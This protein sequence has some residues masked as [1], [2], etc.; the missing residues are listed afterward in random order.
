MK[1]CRL[2]TGQEVGTTE[3]RVAKHKRGQNERRTASEA[4]DV[5]RQMAAQYSDAEIAL[6]LNRLRLKTGTGNTWNEVRVRSLRSHWK[7]GRE[8]N[9]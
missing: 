6:T 1:F 3:L 4:I 7:L 5:V 9:E 8:R 2:S